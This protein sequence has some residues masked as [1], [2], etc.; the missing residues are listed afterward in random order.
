MNLTD[1]GANYSP[2]DRFLDIG[3]LKSRINKYNRAFLSFGDVIILDKGR[4]DYGANS[5]EINKQGTDLYTPPLEIFRNPKSH[6]EAF[7][8][9]DRAL[10][11]FF[12]QV[13]K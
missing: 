12:E 6:T 13:I 1:L 10:R 7:N 9:M 11:L 8:R 5:F 4:L 2:L 3:A